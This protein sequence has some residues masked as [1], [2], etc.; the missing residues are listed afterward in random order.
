[1]PNILS[2]LSSQIPTVNVKDFGAKGDGTTDNTTALNNAITALGAAITTNGNAQLAFPQ[3]TYLTDGLIIS[4]LSNFTITGPGKIKLN[5][6]TA[7]SPLKNTFNVLTLI[8]C[9]DFTINGLEVDGNRHTD[10]TWP[11]TDRAPVTQY[12]TSTANSGQKNVVVSDGTKFVVGEKVWVCGGLTANAGADHDKV[13]N[14]SQ[15]GIAIDSISGNTLTLHTNL[16]NTYTATGSAGGAYVTTYQTGYQ[17]AVGTYTLGNED[18]QNGIHLLGCTKF[19]VTNCYAHDIWE[20]PIKCGI[21]FDTDAHNLSAACT[22]GI[23]SNNRLTRGYDQGVSV[24]NSQFITVVNNQTYD[25]G[26]GGV[27]LTGSDDCLVSNNI[28]RDARY[29]IPGDNSSGYGAVIEGGARNL[30][31]NNQITANYNAGI[32]LSP[33]P[34]TFGVSG[35]TLN[36]NLSWGSTSIP[37]ASGTGFIIG[38]TYMINDG[39]HSES[40]T[41]SN[42]VT[43]TITATEKTRFYHATGKAVAKRTAE[44]NTIEDNQITESVNSYGVWVSPAVRCNIRHNTIQRN[45][46]KGM[47][48]ETSNSFTSGGNIVDGNYFSG[49]GNGTGA[50]AILCDTVNDIQIINNRISGNFGD[51][52][53]QLKG[54]TNGKLVGN[55]ISDVQSNGIYME[56]GG[57]TICSKI[58]I[59]NNDIKQCDG[60]GIQTDKANHLTITGNNCW[61]NAGDGG[62]SLGGALHCTVKGNTC[63]GNNSNGILLKQSSSVD[64]AWNFIEG[65][66]VRDDGSGIKGSDGSTLTQGVSIKEQD[67]GNNN[68]IL[69]NQV[70]IASSK[71]GAATTIVGDLIN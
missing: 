35:T 36:G 3:G 63:I 61:A 37:V 19:L 71:V 23:I 65:N 13:D 70:D 17:N 5:R 24:W 59:A 62:I 57:S 33:S 51:K 34:L 20:S 9:T 50:Q 14:N 25:P 46:S 52:G 7:A 41:V 32:L 31:S 43:N 39:S 21:G 4:G 69:N 68:R 64:C 54:V 66:V 38:A 29:R 56:T 44:D 60:A 8:S 67:S 45:Y 30:I 53:I 47:L 48:I 55:S 42:V 27:V 26:W 28:L 2:T 15:Q 16:S 49:N 1:M 12:L 11:T 18:Q 10:V 58:V 40:F 6:A 22:Y